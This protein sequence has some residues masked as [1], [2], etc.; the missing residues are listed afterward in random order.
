MLK[1]YASIMLDQ[2]CQHNWCM[3]ILYCYTFTK[4]IINF[5]NIS[6]KICVIAMIKSGFSTLC[7]IASL[8][9]FTQHRQLS[10]SHVIYIRV[11]ISSFIGSLLLFLPCSAAADLLSLGLPPF[12]LQKFS[13]A[14]QKSK[15]MNELSKPTNSALTFLLCYSLSLECYNFPMECR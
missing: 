7:T 2:L 5:S 12:L 8:Y 14:L 6:R 15:S 3:P 11:R 13:L 9:S 1:A 4:E 10:T